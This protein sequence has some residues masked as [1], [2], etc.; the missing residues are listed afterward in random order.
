MYWHGTQR[1]V[2]PAETLERISPY[3]AR[4]GLTRLA[5]ITGLDRIGVPVVLSVRP[6]A[7]Y[8][9]LD[10]GKGLTLVAAKVSAAMECVERHHAQEFRPAEMQ[11]SYE[12]LSRAHN[13]VPLEL[14]P[15]TKHSIF[16]PKLPEK[17]TLGWDIIQQAD[18]AVPAGMVPM[19]RFRFGRAD[20]VSFQTG[21][22]GLASG[23]H[24]LEALLSGLLEV[25]ER[26]AVACH[27]TAF[28]RTQQPL[29]RVRTATIDSP[30][31]QE[32]LNRFEASG[33]APVLFDC[34]VDT[35]VPVYMA[36]IYDR[37][38][39]HIGL[40]RGYGAHLDPEVAMVRALTE[41]AQ[42]RCV[43]IAGSRDDVFR[44]SFVRL[45]QL[46][47]GATTEAVEAVPATVDARETPSQATA[48]FE[49]D[50]RILLGKL[51]A[52]GL[53]NAVVFDLSRPGEP[54]AVVRVVAPGMEGYM[55]DDYA[56]G[57]RA[58]AFPESKQP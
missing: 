49:A 24:F 3:F 41:A 15:L 51:Q 52:V 5:D 25:I 34:R 43:Y 11:L 14:L 45:K 23:N 21:T 53:Q 13:I 4:V 28:Q 35:D 12:E 46:D 56:P 58:R 2:E 32:L 37:L 26:D 17:W 38:V 9:A 19:D 20:L 29:P 42:S 36:Y 33:V 30:L 55:I 10:A 44:R 48:T 50:I 7:G 27:M 16:S 1:S 8:L 40:Y 54:F 47:H 57:P 22:N 6:N 31:V 18:V 39:R